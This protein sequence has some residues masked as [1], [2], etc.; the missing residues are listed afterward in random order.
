MPYRHLLLWLALTVVAAPEPM[1]NVTWPDLLAD[2]ATVELSNDAEASEKWQASIVARP[3]DGQTLPSLVVEPT[4]PIEVAAKGTGVFRLRVADGATVPRAV[5]AQYVLILTRTAGSA[6]RIE[7]KTVHIG[8]QF[9]LA[10]QSVK[11]LLTASRWFP[12]QKWTID[13]P[14]ALASSVPTDRLTTF[15][16]RPLGVVAASGSAS[17]NDLSA[18]VRL[19]TTSGAETSSLPIEIDLSPLSSGKLTGVLTLPDGQTRDV[20]VQTHDHFIYPLVLITVGVW[21]AFRVKRYITRDRVLSVLQATMADTELR[22][23]AVD[24]EFR[25]KVANTPLARFEILPAWQGFRTD[26][27]SDISMVRLSGHPL[28]KSNAAFTAVSDKIDGARTLPS[29]WRA[30]GAALLQLDEERQ[31]LLSV[32]PGTLKLVRPPALAKMLEDLETG[33]PLRTIDSLPALSAR[34]DGAIA[35]VA[36][37]RAA[38]DRAERLKPNVSGS[39]LAAVEGAQALLWASNTLTN[40]R[41]A[42]D[43]IDELVT[44]LAGSTPVPASSGMAQRESVR[45]DSAVVLSPE[46]VSIRRKDAL[47]TVVA[48]AV[49]VLGGMNALVF[50]KPF[51]SVGDYAA[52]LAWALTAS[53]VVDIASL[54]LDRVTVGGPARPTRS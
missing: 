38:W 10:P 15:A 42:S 20:V 48:M 32:S 34:I 29:A 11:Y 14:L 3:I 12:F 24:A 6:Q 22:L 39:D 16:G 54:A 35:A 47:A 52:V 50:G 19:G 4:T 1:T 53:I 25:Q 18:V 51:G 36:T 9:Q 46:A 41:V 44:R 27:E 49:A 17:S 40:V 21:C 7:R 13:T 8:P 5:N 45:I 31:D 2:R 26:V 30:F 43:K 28:D 23:A 33:E 37:W